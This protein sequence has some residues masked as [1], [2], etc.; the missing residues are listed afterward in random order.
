MLLRIAQRSFY[1]LLLLKHVAQA[2]ACSAAI[3]M[4]PTHEQV[5]LPKGHPKANRRFTTDQRDT[6]VGQILVA[7]ELCQTSP[8]FQKKLGIWLATTVSAYAP[9]VDSRTGK[10]DWMEESPY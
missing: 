4:R 9:F 1:C 2:A 10:L 5:A 8:E 3:N 6:W 7:C